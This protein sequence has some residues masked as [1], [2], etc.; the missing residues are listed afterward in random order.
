M[1]R[2]LLIASTMT[3]AMAMGFPGIIRSRTR[4]AAT[5]DHATMGNAPLDAAGNMR[6]KTLDYAFKTHD[7][8]RTVDSTGA[9]LVGE[10]ERLDQTLNMPLAAVTWSRD[11]DLREDVSL[12]DEVSSFTL[13]TFGSAGNLGA[14]NGI[15]NGKAWIGKATD[16]IGGVGVDTGKYPNPLT[17]WGLEVKFTI[18]ELES[19]IKMGRPIDDQKY[20]ALKLKQQMDTDEQV[21]VGDANINVGGLVNSALV[22]NISNVP[23]GA[24]ASP[25]WSSKTPGEILA[26]V[27]AMIISAWQ[28][29]GWAVMPTEIRLPP[30]QFGYIS[31]QLISTAGNTSILKYIL[32]NNIVKSS[33][34]GDINIAPVKWLIGA[35]S[36]GTIGTL[37]TVDRMFAYTKDKKFVRFPMTPLQRTPIQYD[38]IYHKS[39]YYNRLGV[40]E[41]VYPETFVYRDGI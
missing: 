39:T 34:K 32:E 29:S 1:K 23:N 17:P 40:T 3:Q 7:G 41:V 4:D 27:N 15:R 19:A 24:T 30:A 8:S 21:Y 12:A 20:E 16:Q 26:D 33:G 35:G 36:G 25:L 10:L 18:L 37:G 11:V 28:A 31:T 5:F 6:G 38:S 13:T 14:G 9:F 22:T 2:N